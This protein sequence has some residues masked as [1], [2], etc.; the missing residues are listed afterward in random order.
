MTRKAVQKALRGHL[1]VDKCLHIQ[2]ITDVAKDNPKIPTLLDQADEFY[3]SLFSA[4][5]TLTDDAV[6]V[7]VL[8]LGTVKDKEL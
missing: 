4:E 5:M 7:V 3:S 1:H 6:L 2:I 8:K